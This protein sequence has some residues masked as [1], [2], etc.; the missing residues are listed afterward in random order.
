[1]PVSI[2]WNKVK[3]C[4][5]ICVLYRYVHVSFF[6]NLTRYTVHA[7]LLLHSLVYRIWPLRYTDSCFHA[8]LLQLYNT[9]Y[10]FQLNMFHFPLFIYF[11]CLCLEFDRCRVTTQSELL[12]CKYVTLWSGYLAKSNKTNMFPFICV[13]AIFVEHSR[14]HLW[15]PNNAPCS[16]LT[17]VVMVFLWF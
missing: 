12:H 2:I 5:H 3:L 9:Y 11:F 7:D 14:N 17:F 6:G 1:M 4:T 10:L 13:V 16:A 8:A 15:E